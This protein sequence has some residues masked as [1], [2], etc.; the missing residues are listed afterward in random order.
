MVDGVDGVT[1]GDSREVALKGFSGKHQLY[2][3]SG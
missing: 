1:I 2:S 3:V